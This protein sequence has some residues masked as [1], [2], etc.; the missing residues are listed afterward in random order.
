MNEEEQNKTITSWLFWVVQIGYVLTALVFFVV[1][2]LRM[3]FRN[4]TILL[5]TVSAFGRD[6]AGG[7]HQPLL[8]RAV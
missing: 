5:T 3:S 8:L 6:D 2:I 7:W 1:S 4:V